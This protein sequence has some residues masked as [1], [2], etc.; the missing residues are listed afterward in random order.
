MMEFNLVFLSQL[1]PDGGE[2]LT[3]AAPWGIRL[4]KYVLR[5]VLCHLDER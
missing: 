1:V 2:L 5:R 4:N 3:V